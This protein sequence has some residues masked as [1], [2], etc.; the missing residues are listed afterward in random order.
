MH[1]LK[2]DG[3]YSKQRKLFSMKG[4]YNVYLTGPWEEKIHLKQWNW[5]WESQ[6]N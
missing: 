3:Y 2:I 1:E 4:L 5:G 6:K